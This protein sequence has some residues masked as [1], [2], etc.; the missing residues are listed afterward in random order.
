MNPK[1]IILCGGRGVRAFPFTE[2]LPKPMLPVGG[3]PILVH[4]IRNYAAQGF[5]DFVLAAGYRKSVLDD[6]FEAKNLGV[7]IEI[8]DTGENADTGE[9]ILACR[10]RVRDTFMVTYGDGISDVPIGR[11]LA[12]HR[13]MGALATVT[14]VP[15]VSQYG[16]IDVDP[17]GWVTSMREKPTMHEHW[18]NAGFFV[19][20]PGVF[21][22]WHGKNL[23]REIMG[24]WL[25]LGRLSAYRHE[26]FFKSLDSYKDQQEFD[27]I[28]NRGGLPGQTAQRRTA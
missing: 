26:G 7:N 8:L 24:G 21:D 27:E 6:Y 22:N 20:D 17:K 3:T 16:V 12:H 18:I 2:Y 1:V 25:R 13:E 28:F 23:E 10:D 19:M 5:K 15:L 4:I 11:L 9:R 14:C